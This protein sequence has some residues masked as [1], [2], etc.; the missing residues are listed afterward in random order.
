MK[1]NNNKITI[2]HDRSLIL[3]ELIILL[4]LLIFASVLLLILFVF[5]NVFA[6]WIGM[7]IVAIIAL[8]LVRIQRLWS[9]ILQ[10]YEY[11]CFDYKENKFTH[12]EATFGQHAAPV[13]IS[14]P[15]DSI[16]SITEDMFKHKIRVDFK[17]P[18]DP[19]LT[20]LISVTPLHVNIKTFSLT[21]THKDIVKLLQDIIS[22]NQEQSKQERRRNRQ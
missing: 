18:G 11:L 22:A 5:F 10:K 7:I 4:I 14:F 20:R 12:H 2:F 8:C 15:F 21:Y 17:D 9:R 13:V 16:E 6:L 3:K 19:F 1:D